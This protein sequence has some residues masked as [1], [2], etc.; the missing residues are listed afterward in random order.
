MKIKLSEIEIPESN[1][2][3]NDVLKREENIEVL[4]QLVSTLTGPF[5]LAID[6]EWG[7]GKTTFL[8]MW[9]QQLS[10]Q[11]TP[12]LFFNAW[13]NDFSE[14][15]LVSL[16]GEIESQISTLY[17][18]SKKQSKARKQLTQIKKVGASLIRKSLPV[19]VKI[20]TSGILDIEKA[21]EEEISKLAESYAKDSID[22]YEKSKSNISIFRDRLQQFVQDV[23]SSKNGEKFPLLFFI[24]EL[25]RCRP[26][27]AL[28]LLEKIKH[29]FNIEGLVFVLSLDKNQIGNS[30]KSL[31]GQGMNVDG[32][33]RRFIDL[34]YR[35]PSPDKK[36]YCS[37]LFD[38]F[39]I[40]GYLKNRTTREAQHEEEHFIETF[41]ELSD[42]FDFSLRVQEQCFSQFC[43]AIKTTPQNSK[44][45]PTLL[46][47]LVCIKAA[48]PELYRD[49]VSENVDATSIIN[50]IGQ[51]TAGQKFLYSDEGTIL[52]AL[53]MVSKCRRGDLQSAKAPY[54]K[55]LQD[56][57]ISEHDIKKAERILDLFN[58]IQQQSDYGLLDYLS[59]KIEISEKFSTG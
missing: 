7:T 34:D 23:I 10:N 49:F 2:F 38:R 4:T 59:K 48:S 9:M 35:L 6:S 19:A 55:M 43:I 13:E 3:L 29:L 42:I 52:E 33:L 57:N 11:A 24:D 8:K 25:D 20:A 44:L 17:V 58:Y 5:V 46:A 28:E 14:N 40:K 22:K 21:Y 50:F 30:I 53:L 16:I 18:D 1:P 12:F 39:G 15:A 32:Y 45:C 31:Y 37:T 27:Y 41:A 54:E 51:K 36:I 26:N 47:G 56:K